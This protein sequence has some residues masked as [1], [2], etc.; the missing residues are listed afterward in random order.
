[1]FYQDIKIRGEDEY[2]IV[3]YAGLK[4]SVGHGH[5]RP[6]HQIVR[7]IE[8]KLPD[9]LSDLSETEVYCLSDP[10]ELVSDPEPEMLRGDE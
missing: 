3:P 7:R 4:I 6:V 9:I 1:M 8:R 5:C 10:S 2:L